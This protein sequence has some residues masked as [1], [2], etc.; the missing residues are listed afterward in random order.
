MS[1]KSRKGSPGGDGGAE[2]RPE[3]KARGERG[4]EVP[5][6]CSDPRLGS[7]LAV[8]EDLDAVGRAELGRHVAAC[9]RCG[10]RWELL[11]RAQ[12]WLESGGLAAAEEPCPA[13]DELYDLC[14]GPGAAPLAPE[15]ERALARHLAGCDACRGFAAT[16][17]SPVPEALLAPP[18]AD[19]R[20]IAPARRSRLRALPRPGGPLVRPRVAL[21][22][23]AAVLLCALLVGRFGAR[24]A[25]FPEP[26]V[27][28]GGAGEEMLF[29]RDL[30]L[31]ARSGEGT[32]L[33][34]VFELAPEGLDGADSFSVSLLSTDGGAF[35][36]G[37]RV[38]SLT[39][40]APRF[41]APALRLAPGT[42]TWEA[43]VTVRGLERFLGARDFEV[44][45]DHDLWKAWD[46]L[47]REDEPER[48]VLRV[49]LLH[50]RGYLGDARALARTLPASPER[51][52]Y[53]EAL[54]G[55]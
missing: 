43:R 41:E 48:G 33:P 42:Y 15:R 52:A 37:T 31:A 21:A 28:R 18:P 14:G 6:A 17:A 50:E 12:S 7:L 24:D 9:P 19:H 1:G 45:V 51:D 2:S 34:L 53:L 13:P 32:E 47:E 3:M 38:A 49:R 8:Y 23:A 11:R 36:R 10:P 44:A 55:R 30:V 39:G 26:P 40:E 29:P 46:A 5:P 35:D 22:A 25:R 27:L 54:P 4:S 20:E 16:L